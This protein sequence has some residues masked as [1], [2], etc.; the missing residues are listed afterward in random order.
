MRLSTLCFSGLIGAAA[1]KCVV[2]PCSGKCIRAMSDA[3]EIGE[4]FCSSYLSLEPATV[5]ITDVSTAT[6]IQ[7]N[8]ETILSV[9]TV[10]VSTI[11]S[12][13]PTVTVF[14]KRQEASASVDP[15]EHILSQC[16][17]DSSR[18]SSACSCLLTATSTLTVYESSTTTEVSQTTIVSA[19][20]S[21][22]EVTAVAEATPTATVTQPIINGDFERY[23]QSGTI[24]PWVS[25]GFPTGG[26]LDV[27][28]P[29]SVCSSDGYCPGGSV[30]IRA[31]PPKV[32]NSYFA[33]SQ[34]SFTAKASATYDISVL[35]RCLNYDTT[36][37]VEVWYKGVKAGYYNCPNGNFNK[38]TG[39]QITTDET[40]VGE[41]EMRFVNGGGLPYLYYYADDFRATVVG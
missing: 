22:T 20:T 23:L 40:G 36:S 38:R 3:V 8:V 41:L 4:A 1:S 25:A 14:E 32:A 35:V 33:I 9:E 15:T 28:S 39:I 26:S 21:T 31:Y 30:I 7:T 17:S 19:L 16:S 6:S 10:T 18:L 12:N 11:T 24:L 13:A 29:L 27:I 2:R 37:G 5:T 34:P